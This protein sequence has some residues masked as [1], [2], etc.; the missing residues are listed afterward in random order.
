[1]FGGAGVRMGLRLVGFAGSIRAHD[2]RDGAVS[3]ST[4][5][6]GRVFNEFQAEAKKHAGKGAR[7]AG[8]V[9]V[10]INAHQHRGYGS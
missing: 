9:T 5:I 2:V 10:P 4:S 1:M 8:H 3:R 7:M 6:N